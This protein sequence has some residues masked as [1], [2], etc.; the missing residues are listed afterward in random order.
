MTIF[1]NPLQDKLTAPDPAQ[2]RAAQA[3]FPGM[4]HF[5]G[6]GPRGMTCRDCEFWFHTAYDYYSK[7]GK[8]HGLI[9]PATCTKY[10]MLT[11]QKGALV[12]DNAAACRHFQID[13]DP[14]PRFARS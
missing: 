12:P 2:T 14:P 9:R 1:R 4:A 5:A 13:N 6:T 11:G 3:S 10:R 8:H 7:T